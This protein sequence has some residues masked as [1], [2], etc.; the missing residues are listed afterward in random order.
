MENGTEI[1]RRERGGSCISLTIEADGE[2]KTM[3]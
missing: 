1:Y 2:D 3:K